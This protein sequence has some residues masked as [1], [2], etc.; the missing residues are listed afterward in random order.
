MR[1]SEGGRYKG[2]W[3]GPPAAEWLPNRVGTEAS[4]RNIEQ[5]GEGKLGKAVRPRGG[6]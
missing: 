4:Q 5:C 6:F 1:T 3:D 2:K